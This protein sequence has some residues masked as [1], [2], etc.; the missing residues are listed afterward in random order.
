MAI[1]RNPFCSMWASGSIA[2]SI[3]CKAMKGN[4]FVIGKHCN[5]WGKIGEIQKIW[6]NEFVRKAS[7][8]RLAKA[9]IDL[10]QKIVDVKLKES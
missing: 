1:V 10:I 4:R 3:T 2:E 6:K 8:S 9:N 7:L 5:P